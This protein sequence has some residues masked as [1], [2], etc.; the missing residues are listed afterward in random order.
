MKINV[1]LQCWFCAFTTNRVNWCKSPAVPLRVSPF[2]HFLTKKFFHPMKN[3]R[4][5]LGLLL[6]ASLST[7]TLFS[8][9]KEAA[10]QDIM[11]VGESQENAAV[12]QR[13]ICSPAC[14]FYIT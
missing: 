4:F 10:Q 6:L 8:C 3:F 13:A 11:T 12:S 9:K 14:D 2:N 5:L 1:D 7:I